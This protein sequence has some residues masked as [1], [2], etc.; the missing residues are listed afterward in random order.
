MVLCCCFAILYV[1]LE[2]CRVVLCCVVLSYVILCYA[3][4]FSVYHILYI[5]SFVSCH[6]YHVMLP[7]VV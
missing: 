6:V 2:L 1:I 5:M 7:S 4:S 3:T